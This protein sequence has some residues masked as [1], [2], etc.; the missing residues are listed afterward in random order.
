MM[1]IQNLSFKFDTK[2][3]NYFFKNLSLS[4]APHTMYFLQGDNGVGKSTFFNIM[5]GSV[6]KHTF[7]EGSI[8]L[9]E[10]TYKLNDTV[11]RAALTH[12]IHTVEQ[13]YDRM[14]A[15][16]YTVR[17]NLQLANLPTYPGFDALAEPRLIACMNIINTV[18]DK[19]AYLLSGGQRQLLA[20]LMALQ[21]PTK[22]LLLD[23]PTATLDPKNA[24]L[25][26]EALQH[27]AAALQVTMLVICHDKELVEQYA[28]GNRM[29]MKQLEN[30]ERVFQ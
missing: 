9:D 13:E 23:E 30:G 20:I 4:F 18:M 27:L 16:L 11:S 17:E 21:K 15:P 26:M 29:E 10:I 5:Q 1:I 8:T 7:L 6:E 3:E 28:H 25:V 12:Q 22:I 14:I 24:Q 2:C 19:P